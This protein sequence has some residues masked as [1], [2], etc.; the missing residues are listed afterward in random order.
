LFQSCA[1]SPS[2]YFNSPNT[3]ALQTAFRQIGS[4][5]STLRISQ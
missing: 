3:A 1:S 5:L 2:N 4:D